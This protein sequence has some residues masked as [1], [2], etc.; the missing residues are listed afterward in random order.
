M[1]RLTCNATVGSE[2]SVRLAELTYNVTI[3]GR[4]HVGQSVCTRGQDK[5]CVRFEPNIY[6]LVSH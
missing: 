1:P 5:T 6:H 3:V 2:A 4:I